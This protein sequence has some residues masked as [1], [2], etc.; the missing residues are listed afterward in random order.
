MAKRPRKKTAPKKT[1]AKRTARRKTTAPAPRAR[2]SA[3]KSGKKTAPPPETATVKAR[4]E[5]YAK[6]LDTYEKALGAMQGRKFERAAAGFQDVIDQFPEERELHERVL[7]YLKVCERETAPPA[8]TPRTVDEL[9][10][11][12]TLALNGGS[13]KVAWGHLTTALSKSA[14]HDHVH[15]MLAVAQTLQGQ[16][17]T[18]LEH[19]CRAIALNPDNRQLAVQDPD[20]D[21]LRDDQRFE[22]ALETAPAKKR[23]KL[24]AS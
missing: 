23:P 3:R 12:A 15:Y 10:Y 16:H 13:L 21:G 20:F 18:A 24:R 2:A 9:I 5:S 22:E 19:L 7:L 4:R 8:P 14:D 6:A 17:D 1:A 11:A